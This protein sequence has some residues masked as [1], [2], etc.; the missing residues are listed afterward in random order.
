MHTTLCFAIEGPLGQAF[1][2]MAMFDATSKKLSSFSL[3][4]VGEWRVL[5]QSELA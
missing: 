3:I 5:L 4:R 2:V 1:S